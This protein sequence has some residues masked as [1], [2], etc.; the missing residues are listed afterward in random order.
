M[1]D[2]AKKEPFGDYTKDVMIL[3]KAVEV[4]QQKGAFTMADIMNA[5]PAWTRVQQHLMQKNNPTLD[6]EG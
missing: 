6:K 1:P 2:K 3:L 4:A 5:A